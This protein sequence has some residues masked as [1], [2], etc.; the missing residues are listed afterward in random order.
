MALNDLA[1]ELLGEVVRHQIHIFAGCAIDHHPAAFAVFF[2]IV[3]DPGQTLFDGQAGAILSEQGNVLS[4]QTVEKDF[5]LL[6]PQACG[7]ILAVL[8]RCCGCECG[9]DRPAFEILDELLDHQVAF[10]KRMPPVQNTVGLIHNNQPGAVV[11]YR[12]LESR[13]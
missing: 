5:W 1:R 3:V 6:H 11:T 4:G 2:N 8:R 7:N 12:F 9:N 10:P 13:R